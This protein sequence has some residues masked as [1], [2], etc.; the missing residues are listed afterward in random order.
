MTVWKDCED[1]RDAM[2]PGAMIQL[3]GLSKR[4]VLHAQ[5]GVELGVLENLSLEVA[6]G[7]CVA[8]DGPSG[9]GKSTLLRT[10]YANYKADDGEIRVRHDGA[11]VDL[12]AAP[13][14]LVL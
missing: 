9:V 10:V 3:V 2:N 12:A 4:F 7:E 11:L 13:P 1:E 14:R 8:L 5:G 6:R